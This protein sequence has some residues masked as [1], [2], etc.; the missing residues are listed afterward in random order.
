MERSQESTAMKILRNFIQAL[1]QDSYSGVENVKSEMSQCVANRQPVT[2]QH[3]SFRLNR[4]MRAKRR[5]RGKAKSG[6][7]K[8]VIRVTPYNLKSMEN[9]LDRLY[10]IE[11]MDRGT[12]TG[13]GGSSLGLR[14]N[15]DS[16]I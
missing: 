12:Q 1:A 3:T 5:K 15:N 10:H 7:T 14:E 8:P 16:T 2:V 6:V 9:L 13:S 11:K 4:I